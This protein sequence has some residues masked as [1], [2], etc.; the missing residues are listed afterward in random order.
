MTLDINKP[1]YHDYK[2]ECVLQHVYGDIY[3]VSLYDGEPIILRCRWTNDTSK[4][5]RVYT[6]NVDVS[7]ADLGLALHDARLSNEK[8]ELLREPKQKQCVEPSLQ[9]YYQNRY[10][11]QLTPSRDRYEYR[12]R[13]TDGGDITHSVT[14]LTA[15]EFI[16]YDHEL[17]DYGLSNVRAD[18]QGVVA[19][20]ASID[21][22][23]KVY[24]DGKHECDVAFYRS[25]Y[26]LVTRRDGKK[27]KNLRLAGEGASRWM[28]D[29]EHAA[30]YSLSNEQVE[31]PDQVDL[32]KPVYY[33]GAPCLV[34]KL[35]VYYRVT[36]RQGEPKLFFYS[37]VDASEA[38]GLTNSCYQTVIRQTVVDESLVDD[39][40][41]TLGEILDETLSRKSKQAFVATTVDFSKP[42]YYKNKYPVVDLGPVDGKHV[43]TRQDRGSITGKNGVEI[44]GGF[45]VVMTEDTASDY[46]VSN[47]LD[48]STPEETVVEQHQPMIDLFLLRNTIR[49][50][51][52]K[53]ETIEKLINAV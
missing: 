37:L 24:Y 9:V 20:P 18:V 4:D 1:V 44:Q 10:E 29:P 41:E 21:F 19:P 13:R 12:V 40:A 38:G 53:I 6:L 7:R 35:G 43:V 22:S 48:D 51:K 36:P 27:M 28:V 16:A 47:T 42:L 17:A 14:G 3:C 33:Q 2:H 8:I 5:S 46:Y 32:L 25:Y 34:D 23:K 45:P 26:Y 30:E 49:E 31:V 50:L 39:V 15:R 11:C 52:K